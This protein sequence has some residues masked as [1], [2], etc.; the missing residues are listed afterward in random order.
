MARGRPRK[1]Q[2]QEGGGGKKGAVNLDF[3]NANKKQLEFFKARERFI[4]Y[5]GAKG[6]GKTWAVR[7]KAALGALTYEG[8]RILIIRRTYNELLENH[9]NPMRKMIP[10]EV[11]DLNMTVKTMTFYNGSIIKFGNWSGDESERDYQGIEYDWIFIDEATQ[12]TERTFRFLGGCLRGANDIPKRMYLTCNPGGVGHRWVKRLFIDRQYIQNPDNPEENE[13]P[14]DYRFIFAKV[15]D[16]TALLRSEGG[17]GYLQFLAQMPE[18][19]R[20]AMRD[21]DW[22]AMAGNYFPEFDPKK[23]VVKP[24]QIPA[25]WPRYR[26]IDYGLDAL[27]CYWWAVDAEGHSYCYREFKRSDLIVS[28]AAEAIRNLTAPEE[29]V[30]IT[31]APPDLW[32]RQKDTGRTMAEIFTQNGVPLVKADN[33]RVQGHMLIKDALKI[34]E[35]GK[36]GIMFFEGCRFICDDLRDIQADDD[37]P[38]DC[39]KE[40]HDVTHTVDSV[41][42]FVI[43][44]KLIAESG[45]PEKRAPHDEDGEE[46]D[47]D[48]FMT[49]GEI[50]E[51]YLRYT[52]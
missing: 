41:R 51:S 26:S 40:P 18:N 10:P 20:R 25:S 49:G 52:A 45:E 44:R 3:G 43:S 14:K 15:E 38:S 39:A 29:N 7:V 23:H 37:N 31:F 5:G 8:I 48:T 28:A 17:K 32:S 22:G 47:Y 27:A 13:D 21:G 4:A 30:Q 33:N 1:Q 12:F 2:T 9:I 6:G 11:G 35:D 34:G 42:Y 16:N 24:F 50:S 36:P 46:T 19:I